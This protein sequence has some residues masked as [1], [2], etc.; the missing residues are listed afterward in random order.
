MNLLSHFAAIAA[1]VFAI[2]AVGCDSGDG[3]ADTSAVPVDASIGDAAPNVDG[4]IGD[5]AG[6]KDGVIVGDTGPEAAVD[7]GGA[8]AILTARSLQYSANLN[9]V[10]G[11][12]SDDVWIV[13]DKGMILHWNGK[14]LVARA[15]GTSTDLYAAGG[16]GSDD[17][18]F[19]GADGIALHWNGLS[20]VDQSPTDTKVPLRA[21]AAA[22]GIVY[23]AGDNGTVY[24]R[25][26]TGWKLQ[27][28]KAS[29]NLYGIAAAGIGQVWA[30]G[31]QGQAV[32]LAGGSWSVTS[33]PKANKTLRSVATAPSGKLFAVGDASYLAGTN[34]GT[35]EVTLANDPENRDLLGVWASADNQAWAIGKKG[36]LL[37]LVGKKWQLDQISGTYMKLKDFSA[38]WGPANKLAGTDAFA[39]GPEGAGVRY[40]AATDKWMDF[41]AETTADLRQVVTMADGSVVACGT[42]GAVVKAADATAPFYDL[43]APITGSD[44]YDCAAV[45]ETLWIVGAGG[46]A[47]VHNKTGWSV[48]NV[49]SIA[50]L[51][52]I[53]DIG[54]AVIAVGADGKAWSRGPTGAWAVESTATQLPLASVAGLGGKAFAVGAVGTVLARDSAGKWLKE[55]IAETA[56]LH[57]V[58][59]WGDGEALAV[60]DG[61]VMWLRQGAKW[62]KVFEAPGLPLY[63]ALRRSDGTLIAV[64]WAGTLVVGK[65]GASFVKVESKTANVLRGI[66]ASP[67]GTLAVGLKGGVFAVAEVL[68]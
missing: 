28:S 37:H 50:D 17:V 33:L 63:G 11:A 54:G 45:G 68:P 1:V 15:S 22:A 7:S 16:T 6:S 38:I 30:V 24:L 29:F 13:G 23:V 19:V 57:R 35:W 60:G 58:I 20:L 12:T 14:V 61:G 34:A 64:G 31:E 39:V 26:A 51:R 42:Q 10:W 40:D 4:A 27:S 49:S 46:L 59:A 48:E 25:D 32:K 43:A 55:P 56:D 2:S 67:K 36:A 8:K 44:V 62:Q 9:G 66:A 21:V 65:T 47:A 52:G 41:R 5:S 3:A 53:A 18:W